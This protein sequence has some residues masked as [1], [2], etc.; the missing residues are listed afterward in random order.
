MT[1]KV[2]SKVNARWNN[3]H[4]KNNYLTPNLRRLLLLCHSIMQPPFGYP[5]LTWYANL[6]K[7]LKSQIPTSQN[8]CIRFYPQLNKLTHLS[9]KEFEIMNWLSTKERSNQ[10]MNSNVFKNVNNQCPVIWI[11]LL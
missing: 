10:C 7:N 3:I 5:C 4:R 9:Q 11:K 6:F 8:K 2:I 1:R